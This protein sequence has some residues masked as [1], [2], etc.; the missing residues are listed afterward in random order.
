MT[1]EYGKQILEVMG[2]IHRIS[3]DFKPV[4]N[5]S[6]GEFMMLCAI[7]NKIAENRKEDESISSVSVSEINK[8]KGTSKAATS[9]MLTNLEDKNYIERIIDKKD[10][11]VV[12][13]KITEDGSMVLKKTKI[14][15]NKF[16]EETFV[17]LGEKDSKE[18]TRIL[19][20]LHQILREE[21]IS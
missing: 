16:L 21:T 8:F 9:K 10:K 5:I 17:K 7:E 2:K 1:E 14:Q 18:L 6:K 19:N 13:I 12:F 11:R 4:F 20:K 3:S 15:F